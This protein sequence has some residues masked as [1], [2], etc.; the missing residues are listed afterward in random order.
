MVV[1]RPEDGCRGQS[2]DTQSGFRALQ[3]ALAKYWMRQVRFRLGQTP[4]RI[5]PGGSACAKPLELRIDV[6]HPMRR[7]FAGLDF[8]KH[9]IVL[10]LLSRDEPREIIGV[11]GIGLIH[12][13]RTFRD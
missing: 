4:Y 12:R 10:A 2:R 1:W 11:V 8:G 3:Q 6:P 5:A 7:L 13:L 9:A